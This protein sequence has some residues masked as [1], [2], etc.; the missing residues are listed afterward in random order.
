M[1]TKYIEAA[2]RRAE[3]EWLAGDQVFYGH[4]PELAGVWA[5]GKT[6]AECAETLREVVEDWV[7]LGLRDGDEFPVI[8]GMEL[9]FRDA[10][11]FEAKAD[12]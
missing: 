7:M 1:L 11:E 12:E 10:A 5:S 6:Q 9:K 2:M 3:Y 4:V 8:E